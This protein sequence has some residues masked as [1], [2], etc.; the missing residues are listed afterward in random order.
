M[1]QK[2]YSQVSTQDKRKNMLHTKIC[3]LMFIV[4]LFTI[5]PDQKQSKYS[6]TGEW[7]DK[8]WHIHTMIYYIAI[9]R[10][11]L[12]IQA[13]K[14]INLK[15]VIMPIEKRRTE[16]IT[17]SL[18]KILEKAKLQW[19]KVDQRFLGADE[20]NGL[21]VKGNEGIFFRLHKCSIL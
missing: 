21:A 5:A 19:W 18:Q 17:Y 16:K 2:S 12:L 14:S 1:T 20:E 11:E 10:S 4:A 13:T 6:L 9:K 7:I 15:S 8:L 3:T